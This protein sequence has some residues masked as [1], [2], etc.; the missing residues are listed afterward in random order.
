M[1]IVS[2]F[3]TR[4]WE[5]NKR[6]IFERKYAI[7]FYVGKVKFLGLTY[8]T[9]TLSKSESRWTVTTEGAR[10]I[11]TNSAFADVTG[12]FFCALVDVYH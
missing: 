8:A 5:S 1:E 3:G 4:I 10:S 9:P 7:H 11:N 6:N 2:I 12:A